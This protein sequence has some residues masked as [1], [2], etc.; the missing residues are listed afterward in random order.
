MWRHCTGRGVRVAVIDSGV[1]GAHPHVGGLVDG[2]S[3]VGDGD[4]TSDVTDHVGHG[5]AVCAAIREKAP[6]A[7]LYAIKVFGLT[8]STRATRVARGIALAAEAGADVI[9]LSLGTANRAHEAVFGR[10]VAYAAARG[11]I[12]VA[13][14]ESDGTAWLPGSLDGVVPVHLDWDCPRDIVRVVEDVSG[15]CVYASGFPRPIPGVP[16]AANLKGVSFAVA[17]VS[18]IVARLREAEPGARTAAIIA[19]LQQQ[20]VSTARPSVP[21][22]TPAEWSSR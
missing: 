7:E 1:H 21:P 9:N 16:M 8:L 14:R 19:L 11:A 22:S 12:V 2:V 5:T 13:A 18:G 10:A 15:P 3:I 17:N 20:F 4:P 6:D